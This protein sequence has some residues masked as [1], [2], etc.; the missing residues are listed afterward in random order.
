MPLS[1]AEGER[2]SRIWHIHVY[3][4][5]D[6]LYHATWNERHG[7]IY[8]S[9]SSDGMAF[10]D[11]KEILKP[12]YGESKWDN[13]ELYRA[14]LTKVDN[15]YKL[16]YSAMG[17]TIQQRNIGLTE[18][19]SMLSLRGSTNTASIGSQVYTVIPRMKGSRAIYDQLETPYVLVRNSDGGEA[20]VRLIEPGRAGAG[21]KLGDSTNWI[22]VVN[23]N[24][25]S[26]GNLEAAAVRTTY[27][28][29][30]GGASGL[31]LSDL[32]RV[33]D[34]GGTSPRMKL[35]HRGKY[36]AT[37]TIDDP[38]VV[39][40]RGDNESNPGHLEVGSLLLNGEGFKQRNGALRYNDVLGKIQGFSAGQGGWIN[41][42]NYVA[43]VPKSKSS[44]GNRGD[45]ATDDNYL[46][47]CHK[48]NNWLR[49]SSDW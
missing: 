32:F 21:F 45:Y 10:S 41:L 9:T 16:F 11:S 6:N 8:W 33:L 42:N 23:D 40:V 44:P 27:L 5:R 1:F 28:Y 38:D 34:S 30:T 39:K 31:S 20:W 48:P 12:T 29:G 4:E 36:G 37:L 18:G 7:S 13:R 35:V 14:S 3:K 26:L 47:V 15:T 25:Q 49:F 19:H 17:Q 2:E 24:G 22:K 46:Y 43:D